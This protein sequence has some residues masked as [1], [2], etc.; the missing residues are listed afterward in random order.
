MK[1]TQHIVFWIFLI[2]FC[3]FLTAGIFELFGV[4]VCLFG[5][6]LHGMLAVPICISFLGL[7]LCAVQGLKNRRK[8][9][10]K[11]MLYRL[12]SVGISVLCA[13]LLLICLPLSL[14]TSTSYADSR[15]SS[16]RSYKI[17]FEEDADAAEPIVHVYKRYSPFL[18]VYRNSAVL[19]GFSGE[20]SEV[21]VIWSDSVCTVNYP[22]YSEEAES[23]EDMQILSRKIPYDTSH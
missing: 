23:V 8:T 17:F 6:P 2:L 4:S 22:G 5:V 11:P 20:L 16:D 18:A 14:L 10:Q 19:Y 7:S 9:A 13:G 12:L 21:E 1:K 15:I 3:L